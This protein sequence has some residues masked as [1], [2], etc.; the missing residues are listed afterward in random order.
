MGVTEPFGQGVA[1]FYS[2]LL[3]LSDVPREDLVDDVLAGR[4]RLVDRLAGHGV[5]QQADIRIGPQ[6]AQGELRGGDVLLDDR[7]RHPLGLADIGETLAGASLAGQ[8]PAGIDHHAAREIAEHVAILGLREP[9][10]RHRAGIGVGPPSDD[11]RLLLEPRREPLPVGGG[12]ASVSTASTIRSK[13]AKSSCNNAG[14]S[15]MP[16]KSSSASAY[17]ALRQATQCVRTSTAVSTGID[18]STAAS[19]T[20]VVSQAMSAGRTRVRGAPPRGP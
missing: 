1:M 16:V 8:K 10:Q 7:R 19:V 18:G 3:L 4:R 13:S 2:P 14:L 17:S 6:V 11:G 12:I 9:L 20:V 5:P 15:M